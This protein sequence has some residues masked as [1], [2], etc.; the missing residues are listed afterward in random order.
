[1]QINTSI[2]N[3][4]NTSSSYTSLALLEEG[5]DCPSSPLKRGWGCVFVNYSKH[6]YTSLTLL[7]EGTK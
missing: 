4:L 3:F 2:E 1:I 6:L 5:T 7:K